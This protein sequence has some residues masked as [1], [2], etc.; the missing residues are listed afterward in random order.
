MIILKYTETFEDFPKGCKD[1]LSYLHDDQEHKTCGGCG[2]KWNRIE[3]K[4][5]E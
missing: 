5:T 1:K 3:N 4:I 2:T